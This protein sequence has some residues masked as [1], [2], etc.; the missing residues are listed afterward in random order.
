MAVLNNDTADDK[1]IA[2]PASREAA[3]LV[4]IANGESAGL[5]SLGEFIGSTLKLPAY[6]TMILVDKES[7]LQVSVPEEKG[8]VIIDYLRT[9]RCV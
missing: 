6:T 9:D 8:R 2:I 5:V 4:I 7:S 1:E 3:D